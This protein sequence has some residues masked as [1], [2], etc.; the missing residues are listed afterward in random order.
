MIGSPKQ[1]AWAEQI[2]PVLIAQW[3]E[4]LLAAEAAGAGRPNAGSLV[5]LRG[6]FEY[7]SAIESAPFWIDSKGGRMH[8][9][10]DRQKFLCE[11]FGVQRGEI[12][13]AVDHLLWHVN[14]LAR[15]R[16]GE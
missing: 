14:N 1:I 6:V 5:L 12:L 11:K 3:D 7:A 10:V 16:E 4:A 9:D 2:R 13:R 15:Q 8:L